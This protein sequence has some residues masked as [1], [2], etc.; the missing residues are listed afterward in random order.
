MVR[1]TPEG[2]KIIA[3]KGDYYGLSTD[4]KVTLNFDDTD[5]DTYS[6]ITN[7]SG[8]AL[9]FKDEDYLIHLMFG[10]AS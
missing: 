10:L 1:C 8:K 3:L 9:F 6:T 2:E 4:I 7:V 5:I